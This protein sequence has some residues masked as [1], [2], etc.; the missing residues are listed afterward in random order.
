MSNHEDLYSEQEIAFLGALW[1][2]GYL[3]PGGADEVRRVLEGID[4]RGKRV[5][6]IGSGTGAITLSLAVEYGAS[7]VIGIDVEE[8]VCQ[9]ARQRIAKAGASDHVEIRQVSPGPIL[10]PDG[11]FDIIF[12][13][14]S[15]V[16]IAD[17]ESLAQDA[18]RL[19]APGGW[20]VASDW[21]ISHDGEPSPEMKT[22]IA[23]EDLDFGMASPQ[24]YQQALETAG[25]MNIKLKNRNRWYL[26]T[27][28]TELERLQGPEREQFETAVSATMLDE[29]IALWQAMLKVLA[30]GE[31][32]PHHFRG[33]KPSQ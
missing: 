20:F 28:Q 16:H 21:L 29:Q 15:I 17:K 26:A 18:F 14:D 23:M 12:S 2:D 24:R 10:L 7:Q 33:Q 3:S 1:G 13:K 8:P 30:T 9:H 31:H 27:A 6:D 25:F 4:L 32:C 5:L 22:Y 19:L 11:L